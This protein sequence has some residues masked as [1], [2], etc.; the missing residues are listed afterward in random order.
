MFRG[1]IIDGRGCLSQEDVIRKKDNHKGKWRLLS[2]A[3]LN[4]LM[5]IA[6]RILRMSESHFNPYIRKY[7]QKYQQR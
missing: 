6:L 1:W 7:M 4:C 5:R 2:I 3:V